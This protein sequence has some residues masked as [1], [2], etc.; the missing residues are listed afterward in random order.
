MEK[1][2]ASKPLQTCNNAPCHPKTP[3]F[4]KIY[5]RSG[6]SYFSIILSFCA[7][8]LEYAAFTVPPLMYRLGINISHLVH[9]LNSGEKMYLLRIINSQQVHFP[10]NLRKCTS[11]ESINLSPYIFS[12]LGEIYQL[13]MKICH[14]VHFLTFGEKCTGW[15]LLNLS[16]YIFSIL[17]EIYQLRINNCHPVH[18]LTFGEKCTGWELLNLSQYIFSSCR[19]KQ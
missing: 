16:Q 11:W 10:A 19:A 9:F 5:L 18:F 8:G 13:R 15:E 14:P 7:T 6:P 2:A 1:C 4:L 17:G 3:L 12:I